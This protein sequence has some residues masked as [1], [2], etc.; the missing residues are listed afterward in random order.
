MQIQFRQ[1]SLVG[2]LL[3]GSAV[4]EAKTTL[5]Q[6]V[7][8][9]ISLSPMGAEMAPNADG[10]IPAWKG[11]M[12][13][14]PEGLKYDETGDIYPNPYAPE[15]P[16]FTITANNY[17]EHQQHLSEGLQ[18][19]FQRYPDTFKMHIYPTHRDG[20]FS[21]L[22]E[23]RTR[24]NATKT[25]LSNGVD[26][27][28]KFTGG[29]PFPLPNNG[30][31]VIHNARIIHPHGTMNGVMDD[32]AVYSNNTRSMR[33]QHMISDF[34]F[35][36][37]ENE[38][39]ETEKK[40]GKNAAYIHVNVL[41]PRRSKGQMTIVHEAVDHVRSARRAWVYLPGSRRVRRAPTVGYDTPD[42]PG[43]MVTVDDSLGFNGAMDRYEWTLIGKRE[44]Y[45]PYH[46][47]HFDTQKADYKKLLWPGHANPKYMRY[48]KH[49]VWVVEANLKRKSR[50]IYSKRRF[51]IDE[52]SWQ[53]ALLESY[54]NHGD[55][56]RVGILNTLYDYHVQGYIARAQMFHDL[57]SGD[58][59]AMRLVNETEPTKYNLK[60]KGK[61]YY[62]PKN[63]RKLGK[64]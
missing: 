25:V 44:M 43:G 47:Y 39:G 32:I 31:E 40:I 26:G 63:L 33:R 21:P 18:A 2:A 5:D 49:R 62:S 54:D 8:M 35:A 6:V 57:Q 11:S 37:Q 9:G 27:L 55:L 36:L 53:F 58:Y 20:R 38:V 16:M 14:L 22:I 19:M 3:L 29:A 10:T 34:P 15:P 50:H 59:V 23:K 52:D 28:K 64:R 24:W 42:G 7:K 4:V 51:Y 56:W 12:L 48:E 17:L 1:L 61:R 46:S 41:A 45:I 13:G 60:P 30:A